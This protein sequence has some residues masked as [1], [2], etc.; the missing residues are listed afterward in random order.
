MFDALS[1]V[2]KSIIGVE[3]DPFAVALARKKNYVR[4]IESRTEEMPLPDATADFVFSWLVFEIWIRLHFYV[5][6]PELSN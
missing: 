6:Y 5:K 2:S 3:L 1:T 4:L